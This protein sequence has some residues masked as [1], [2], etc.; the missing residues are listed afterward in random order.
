MDVCRWMAP[1]SLTAGETSVKSDVWSFG[2]LLWE[3]STLGATPYPGKSVDEAGQMIT[4]GQ[5]MECP[6]SCLPDLYSVMQ[7]CWRLAPEERADFCACAAH[8]DRL[9]ENNTDYLLLEDVPAEYFA[10]LK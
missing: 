1:E 9:L 4:T 7:Q 6:A 8:L 5:H 2:V 3:L 10:D